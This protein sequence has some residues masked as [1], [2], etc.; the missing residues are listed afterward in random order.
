MSERGL[1]ISNLR[2]WN[3]QNTSPFFFQWLI[4]FN[5]MLVSLHS[6][7]A[8]IGLMKYKQDRVFFLLLHNNNVVQL[9]HYVQQNCL[10]KRDCI[11]YL[12][13]DK[14]RHSVVKHLHFSLGPN[15]FIVL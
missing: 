6:T 13:L 5:H 8:V 11:S 15:V 10:G 14:N 7:T 4:H 2:I 9:D 12:M 3:V 1:I